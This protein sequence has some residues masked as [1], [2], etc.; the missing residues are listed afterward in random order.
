M[1]LMDDGTYPSPEH[2]RWGIGALM[3]AFSLAQVPLQ[4]IVVSPS[5][6]QTVSVNNVVHP[7]YIQEINNW[8]KWRLCYEGGDVFIEEYLQKFSRRESQADFRKRM[9]MSPTPAFAKG[10]INEI[11]N[12]VFERT[13]DIIRSGGSRTYQRSVAGQMGGVDLQGGSMNYFIGHYVLPEM[14]TMRT[15]GVYVDNQPQ[16][17]TRADRQGHPYIY[18]YK[19]E[20]IR[21]WAK[22][23]VGDESVYTALLLR[24]YRYII[25]PTTGLPIQEVPVFRRVWLNEDGFVEIQFYDQFGVQDGLSTV[26][27]IREIP[28]EMF[29]IS[30]SL[31]KDIANHQ[32]SLLNMESAD[33]SYAL[34]G[35]LPFY[36]EQYDAKNNNP[37]IRAARNA[38]NA[39]TGN[40]E[41]CATPSRDNSE[42]I[43]V[44]STVGR[45]YGTGLERPGFIAPPAEPLRV[46]MEKQANLKADLR[47]LVHLAVSALQPVRAS[48]E[49]KNYDRQG[50]ETGL[51]YIGLELEHGEQ[52]IAHFWSLY[53]GTEDEALVH[54]PEEWSLKSQEERYNEVDKL[55]AVRDRIPS[56]IFRKEVTKI[57]AKELLGVRVTSDKLE[58]IN[59]EIDTAPGITADSKQI[60]LDLDKG[61][62]GQATASKLRGYPESEVNQAAK[63][64]AARLT[65][66]QEAQAS[67]DPLKNPAARGVP[68]LAANPTGQS[69]EEKKGKP[70]RGEGK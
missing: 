26:L 53:E 24:E 7:E 66:I 29:E 47:A 64:H 59:K 67:N 56:N 17:P 8:I 30:D 35:N 36:T 42:E 14:L 11:K 68:D 55:Q 13:P 44:G 37:A 3:P 39:Q 4:N 57:I 32:I 1:T 50:L 63:D 46:S 6:I 15:V 22:A 45:R 34:K 61:I 43:I 49:S 60:A 51:S 27:R 21:S 23:Y 12:S 33:V 20:D 52:R 41:S 69:S 62:V 16:G 70:Q 65:R 25:D 38:Y 58:A 18:R 31:M 2:A 54:Y 9:E 28:F 40:S 10:A 48:A 19:A 5:L